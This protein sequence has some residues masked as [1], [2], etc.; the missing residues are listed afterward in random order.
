[1]EDLAHGWRTR[2]AGLSPRIVLTDGDD[3]RTAEAARQLAASTPVRP[4]LV[5]GDAV[6][7]DGVEV[8]SPATAGRDSRIADCLEETLSAR[9]VPAHERAAFARD[10]LY[11]G[12]AAVRTGLADACVGGAA[13]PPRTSCAPGSGSSAWPQG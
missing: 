10:P 3:P 6:E 7:C 2:L 5:S 1:M 4:V 9:G 8:L 11:L 12:A 13:A